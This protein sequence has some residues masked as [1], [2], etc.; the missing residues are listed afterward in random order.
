MSTLGAKGL[1][2]LGPLHDAW[3]TNEAWQLFGE[4]M[5]RVDLC[6]GSW[7]PFAY[8]TDRGRR[9]NALEKG[10]RDCSAIEDGSTMRDH[11]LYGVGTIGQSEPAFH[12]AYCIQL[13]CTFLRKAPWANIE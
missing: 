10:L 6:R 8:P 2:S 12:S 1:K 5:P 4:K 13:S 9:S 3:M 7:W 11:L